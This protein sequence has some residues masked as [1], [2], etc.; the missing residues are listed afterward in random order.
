MSLLNQI[1]KPLFVVNC[2]ANENRA[3]KKWKR[4]ECDL[5]KSG[6]DYDVNFTASRDD[7]VNLVKNDKYHRVILVVGGDGGVNALVEGA[8]RN[9]LEKVLGIIPA[10]TA[11]DIS[12]TF[13][14][15]RSPEKFYDIL[16]KGETRTIDVGEVNKKYFFG[17]ASFGFDALTLNERDKRFF[18]KGKLAYFAAALRALFKYT[19]KKIKMKFN[20][21]EVDKKCFFMVVS[22][23]KY[24]ADGMKIS[25]RAEPDDGLLDF[26]LIEGESNPGIFFNLPSVYSGTHINN[27]NFYYNQSNKLEISSSEPLFLQAD[28]DII[29]EGKHFEFG[30]SDR[31]LK[32]LY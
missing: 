10:G 1:D 5:E 17:H 27:S 9:N 12:R 18:L 28:G 14:I 19:S 4:I 15:Y 8:M 31:K 2:R 25:P 3:P 26:C 22:N 7:A 32:F 23:I 16:L 13:D 24:Y 6:L 30:I 21:Q 20:G 29:S 11:N